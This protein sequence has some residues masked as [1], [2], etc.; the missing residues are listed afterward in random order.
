MHRNFTFYTKNL[1]EIFENET[2][3][4]D[5]VQPR[6]SVIESLLSYSK[7]LEFKKS[8]YVKQVELVLN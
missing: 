1:T 3:T 6:N 7:S 4:D 8:N 2:K 5:K